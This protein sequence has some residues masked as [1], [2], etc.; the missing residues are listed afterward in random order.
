MAAYWFN[1]NVSTDTLQKVMSTWTTVPCRADWAYAA[2]LCRK[3]RIIDGCD[4]LTA[5]TEAIRDEVDR[6]NRTYCTSTEDRDALI[7]MLSLFMKFDEAYK[8]VDAVNGTMRMFIEIQPDEHGRLV[9]DAMC[10]AR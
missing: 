9:V 10:I 2:M 4:V 7:S 8:I 1:G 3:H 5:M 6:Y